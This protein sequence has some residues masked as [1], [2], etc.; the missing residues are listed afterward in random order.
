M[1]GYNSPLALANQMI[2][3]AFPCHDLVAFWIGTVYVLVCTVLGVF[4]KNS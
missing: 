3:Q 4:L 1:T 2:L